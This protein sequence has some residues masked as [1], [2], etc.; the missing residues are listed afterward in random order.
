METAEPCERRVPGRRVL[1]R[2]DVIHVPKCVSLQSLWLPH[3]SD[4]AM[5]H[6][7]LRGIRTWQGGLPSQLIPTLHMP[8]QV[9]SLAVLGMDR[10][11][12]RHRTSRVKLIATAILSRFLNTCNQ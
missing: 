2:I 4:M 9:T 7:L 12:A 1:V 8:T 5:L 6:D 10:Q 3:L 11:T